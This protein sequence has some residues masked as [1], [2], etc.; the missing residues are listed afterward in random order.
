MRQFIA[1]LFVLMVLV[2]CGSK[3]EGD[4]KAKNSESPKT[5]AVTNYPLYYFTQ[6]IAGDEF[7]V[8]FPVPQDLD[9]AFFEPQAE[10]VTL[11]Q[12]A[13]I[14]FINGAGY[15]AWVDKVTLSQRK[16]V[17]T[18]SKVS[19]KYISESGMSHSHGP[20]GEHDHAETAFTTWLDQSIAMGQAK[21]IYETLKES[22][23]E[24]SQVFDN[25]YKVLEEEILELDREMDEL[26]RPYQGKTIYASHPVYQYLGNRYGINIISEHWEP[27]QRVEPDMV[28]TFLKSLDAKELK[29]MLWE[30]EPH[31]ETR[32][33]LDKAGVESVLFITCGNKP[34]NG[35]YLS[36]MNKNIDNLA[37]L[38]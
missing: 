6:K 25:N 38:D 11:Y 14:I 34:E 32:L 28:E 21:L 16:I 19:E 10:M 1:T 29:I 24:F 27:G 22:Y 7:D 3:N 37:S 2:S 36:V 17:N 15:E 9:P 13:D 20:D 4:D 23:P 5:L 26:F 12:S 35:D 18:S 31:P 8:L 30:G 33:L